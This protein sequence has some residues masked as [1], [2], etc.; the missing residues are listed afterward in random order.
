M[1]STEFPTPLDPET[2]MRMAQQSLS[3]GLPWDATLRKRTTK[4][5]PTFA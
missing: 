4:S 1:L 5:Q 3:V 2:E